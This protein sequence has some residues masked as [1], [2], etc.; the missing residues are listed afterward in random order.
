M[1]GLTRRSRAL[2]EPTSLGPYV[3]LVLTSPGPYVT[4]MLTCP[5]PHLILV[6]QVIYDYILGYKFSLKDAID[7]SVRFPSL[8]CHLYESPY[9]AQLWGV[10]DCNKRLVTFGDYYASKAK[11]PAGDYE[12]RLSK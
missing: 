2:I 11:L 9:E 5:G 7:V 4:F 10:F 1:H 6:C 8:A 3:T 12:V